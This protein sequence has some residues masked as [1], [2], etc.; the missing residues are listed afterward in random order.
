MFQEIT[1]L[2]CARIGLNQGLVLMGKSAN[3]LTVKMKSK[4]SWLLMGNIGR[5]PASNFTRTCIAAMAVGA[6]STIMRGARKSVKAKGHLNG[7]QCHWKIQRL[8]SMQ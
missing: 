1:R 3:S 5:N 7:T 6:S 8:R 4:L 2:K